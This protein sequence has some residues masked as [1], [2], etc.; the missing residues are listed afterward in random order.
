MGLGDEDCLACRVIGTGA[1]LTVA[2]YAEN[3]RRNAPRSERVNRIFFASIT[4]V[5][6][7]LGVVRASG[8]KPFPKEDHSK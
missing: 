1:F 5:S 7:V 6:C 3:L 4:A 2:G 8:I